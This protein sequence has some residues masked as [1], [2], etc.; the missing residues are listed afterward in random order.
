MGVSRLHSVPARHDLGWAGAAYPPENTSSRPET[1]PRRGDVERPP[2]RRHPRSYPSDSGRCLDCAA[3]R[4]TRPVAVGGGGSPRNH[5]VSTAVP[6]AVGTERRDPHG[7]GIPDRVR[8]V[9]GDVSTALRSARHDHVAGGGGGSPRKHVVSTAVPT[10][11]GTERRAPHGGGIPDRVRQVRGDVSTA[12][13]SARHDQWGGRGRRI[14]QKPRR[15]DRSP[16]CCRDR[17]ERPP[18][19]QQFRSCPAG[20][21]RCL[22]CAPLRSTRPGVGGGGGSPRKHVV[23]TRVP[24]AVGTERRDLHGGSGPGRIRPIHGGV[25]TSLRFARHDHVAGGG[26]IV[27]RASLP[28]QSPVKTPRPGLEEHGVSE[29]AKAGAPEIIGGIRHRRAPLVHGPEHPQGPFDDFSGDRSL[30]SRV[31]HSLDLFAPFVSRQKGHPSREPEPSPYEESHEITPE[32]DQ[33]RIRDPIRPARGGVSTSLRFARHD[34]GWAGEADPPETTSSRPQSRLLSGRRGETPTEAASPIVSGRFGG[35]SRLRSASL[36]TTRGGQ[37]WRIPQKTRRLD[38]RPAPGGATWRD[39]HGG[40][41]PDRIRQVR[42]GVSTSLRSARHDQWGARRQGS[43]VVITK[44]TRGESPSLRTAWYAS[45]RIVVTVP[46]SI[47]TLRGAAAS[48]SFSRYV[49]RP[50]IPT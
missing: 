49:P 32:K 30:L 45:P 33:A 46:R 19:S 21:W 35:V 14:P 20:S 2:R 34:Q 17:A 48:E 8:Q 37:G 28:Q 6:T 12:L 3:L 25:S 15:L 41:I 47:G 7:G 42:G 9:R 38:Q 31:L 27:R 10:A 16:D 43:F 13:R 4:S 11:V 23:S 18:R 22:D 40:G 36:D 50:C 44:I 26:G 5:V 1:R 29:G 39:P 24:T